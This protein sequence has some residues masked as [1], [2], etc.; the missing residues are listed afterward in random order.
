M[1]SD[2]TKKLRFFFSQTYLWTLG[3]SQLLIFESRLIIRIKPLAD[4]LRRNDPPKRKKL[5]ESRPTTVVTTGEIRRTSVANGGIVETM[6]R[7]D[8]HRSLRLRIRKAQ[9]STRDEHW[10]AA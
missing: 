2:H 10:C 8:S 9:S 4:F 1:Q 7:G 5:E 3:N 6:I